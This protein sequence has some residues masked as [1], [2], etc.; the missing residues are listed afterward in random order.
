MAS[1]E[2]IAEIN[3]TIDTYENLTGGF[4]ANT[5]QM[6][7]NLGHVGALSR[8]VQSADLQTGFRLLRDRGELESTFE[9]VII[10][11]SNEFQAQVVQAAQWR[12]NNAGELID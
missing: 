7:Q 9:A 6:I 11:F 10:R 3:R 5:H 12:L 2:L 4:A 8:L 1:P